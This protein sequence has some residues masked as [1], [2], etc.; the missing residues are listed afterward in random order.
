MTASPAQTSVS[1][2]ASATV[3]PAGDRRISRREARRADDRGDDEIGLAQRR[4]DDRLGTGGDFDRRARRRPPST[5]HSRRDRRSPRKTRSARWRF[6]PARRRRGRPPPPRTSKRPGAPA[7]TCAQERPIEPVAPRMTSRLGAADSR[8]S[9]VRRR[10]FATRRSSNSFLSIYHHWKMPAAI[11]TNS[12]PRRADQSHENRGGDKPVQPI[13][14]AAMA[15]NQMAGIL[16][17]ELPLQRGFE[18][19]AA[20]APR[21]RSRGRSETAQAS[22]LSVG[23][24]TSPAAA[25]HATPT[26]NPDQV[27]AGETRGHSL[28][29]PISRPPK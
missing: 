5:R 25:P 15:G 2:L 21:R 11:S 23:A 14:Q 19:I 18:E 9:D 20:L 17:A 1:L 10:R 22:E 7:I 27:F 3:R 4:L 8:R 28:G 12:V 24:A 29:P 6:S 26:Q 13:H 16:D